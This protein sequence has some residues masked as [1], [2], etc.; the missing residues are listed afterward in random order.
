MCSTIISEHVPILNCSTWSQ[1]IFQVCCQT[2]CVNVDSHSLLRSIT[3]VTMHDPGQHKLVAD[4]K[5]KEVVGG[6]RSLHAKDVIECDV[7]SIE[8]LTKPDARYVS[9]AGLKDTR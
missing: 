2:Y 1:K 6:L 5:E 9:S 7:E 4:S 8:V 3:Q